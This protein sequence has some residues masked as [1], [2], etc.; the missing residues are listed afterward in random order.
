MSIQCAKQ[1]VI[2]M[3]MARSGTS[4]IAGLLRRL[5]LFLGH[6]RNIRDEEATFFYRLNQILLRRIHGDFDN[7]TPMRYLLQ[8][9]SAVETTVRC[10][11]A[12]V[13]SYRIISY[14]G[15][16]R[17]LKYRA[18]ERYDQPWGWKDP[19]NVYTLP[20][21]LKLF[22]RAKIVYIVRNGVDVASSLV[23]FQSGII[24][25]RHIKNQ[26]RS[27]RFSLRRNLELFGVQGAVRCTSMEGS[28]SLW[29]EYVAQAEETLARLENPRM[30]VKYEEFLADP[31]PRLTDLARFCELDGN[32]EIIEDAAGSVDIVRANAFA[33]NPALLSFYERVKDTRWMNHY[34]Y[35]QQRSQLHGSRYGTGR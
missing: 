16:R 13:K 24:N 28:F 34:G 27:S 5:G 7:P 11:E 1:P 21:W 8:D 14:L 18:L 30:F 19:Q 3:G 6:R 25:R 31:K 10:L 20:L 4:L 23:D 29:E 12:D 2:I 15:W 22:P 17:Y 9:E 35:S 32:A 33:G 26:R